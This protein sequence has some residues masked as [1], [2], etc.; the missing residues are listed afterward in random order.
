MLVL[1]LGLDR[2]SKTA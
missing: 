1:N 2:S